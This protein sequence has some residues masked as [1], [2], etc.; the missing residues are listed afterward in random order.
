MTKVRW[1]IRNW[2]LFAW[3]VA[4]GGVAAWIMSGVL[5]WWIAIPA[6]AI[7]AEWMY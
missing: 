2:R 3:M 4:I 7:F 1:V 5:S 6:G